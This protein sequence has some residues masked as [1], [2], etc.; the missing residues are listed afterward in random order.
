MLFHCRWSSELKRKG[1]YN[2]L[3]MWRSTFAQD[4]SFFVFS[5]VWEELSSSNVLILS[6]VS[7][8]PRSSKIGLLALCNCLRTSFSYTPSSAQYQNWNFVILTSLC[9]DHKHASETLNCFFLKEKHIHNL[10]ISRTQVKKEDFVAYFLW[11]VAHECL[12]QQGH[13]YPRLRYCQHCA[14]WRVGELPEQW[15][16]HPLQWACLRLVVLMP[17]SQYPRSLLLHPAII[18][19]VVEA[20]F[21]QLQ[22]AEF[23]DQ[24]KK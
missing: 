22:H 11:A 5:Y 15:C 6:L 13:L 12:V 21:V 24:T 9:G 18:P 20:A 1:E 3:T 7:S 23:C 2:T 14:Q 17:H 8:A 19:L 16:A 4:M 10:G